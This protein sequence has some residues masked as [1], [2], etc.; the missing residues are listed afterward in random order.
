MMFCGF[1]WYNLSKVF[2]Y[3]VHRRM[4]LGMKVKKIEI[5]YDNYKTAEFQSPREEKYKTEG[6]FNQ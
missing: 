1:N 3:W 5:E 6:K 4:T 2:H